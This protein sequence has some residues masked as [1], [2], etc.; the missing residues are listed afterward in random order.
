[1]SQRLSLALPAFAAL[2]SLSSASG[3]RVGFQDAFA[4]ARG[5]A[6]VATA[7]NPSAI[8]YNPAGIARLDGT[9]V[10]ANLYSVS[11]SSDYQ[12]AGGAA[13]IDE[14]PVHVP[15]FYTTWKPEGADW[16]FGFGMYA[17]FGLETEWPAGSPLRNFALR[18]EQ[19]LRTYNFTV[20]WQPA[21]RLSLGGSLTYNRA[22]TDLRRGIGPFGP[23]DLFRFE[24]DG[25]AFGANLG[26]LWQMSDR[27]WLGVSYA[28]STRV[29]MDG[30]SQTLPFIPGE[31]AR[32]TFEFPEVVIAGWSFRPTPDW[33]IE[34]N[35]DWTN[36]DRLNTVAI[37]KPSGAVPLPFNWESGLF[38]ELGVTRYFGAFNLSAGY[39]FTENSVPSST[40]TPAVPDSDRA[41]Y[42]LGAGYHGERYSVDLAYHYA[43]GGKRRVAGSPA[44][45]LGTTADGAYDNS[46]HAIALSVGVKF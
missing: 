10:S 36:W 12:G 31:S 23:N 8:Y 3:T 6:F 26:V 32:A 24:G 21:P 22:T 43:D 16:T 29:R 35:L 19:E 25:D 30:T 4:T 5:N 15:A 33:N 38:Y 11:L 40:Y 34:V 37:N 42:S 2:A 17:P 20:A 18:N 9:R 7:D 1:M 39:C 27:N 14:D 41:F 45:L 13:S 28:H 44:S 46:L